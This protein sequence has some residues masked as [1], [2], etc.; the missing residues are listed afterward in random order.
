MATVGISLSCEIEASDDV[1]EETL[2]TARLQWAR[3]L[4]VIEAKLIADIEQRCPGLK[5]QSGTIDDEEL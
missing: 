5:V 4:E 1:S 3:L 2:N